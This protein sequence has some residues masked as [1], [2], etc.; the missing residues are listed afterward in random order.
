MQPKL[1]GRA[2]S[3]RRRPGPINTG[4][5]TV[6]SA[7]LPQGLCVWIPAF[8]GMTAEGCIIRSAR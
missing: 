4:Q 8:A 1:M 6:S 3:P 5:E 2:P 7:V